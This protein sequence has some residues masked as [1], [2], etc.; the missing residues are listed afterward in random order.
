VSTELWADDAWQFKG[1]MPVESA[2]FAM[3]TCRS[4]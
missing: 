3:A 4:T 2:Y 1:C